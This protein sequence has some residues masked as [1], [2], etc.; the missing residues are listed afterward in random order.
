MNT[1][2]ENRIASVGI[3]RKNLFIE[4]EN[5]KIIK[6]PRSYTKKLSNA[7]LLELLDYAIIGDGIGIHFPTIDEDISLQGILQDLV[8]KL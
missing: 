5:G 7:K 8:N 1:L 3:G 4:L 6:I 2:E